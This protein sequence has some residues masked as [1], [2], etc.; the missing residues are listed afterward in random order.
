MYIYKF[1]QNTLLFSYLLLGYCAKSILKYISLLFAI[2]YCKFSFLLF[3]K[4]FILKINS[5]T[6]LL[7]YSEDVS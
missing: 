6:K 5:I 1:K 4:L 7:S 2:K 3:W